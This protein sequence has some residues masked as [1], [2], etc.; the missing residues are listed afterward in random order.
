MAASG[1]RRGGAAGGGSLAEG[2]E[3]LKEACAMVVEDAINAVLLGLRERVRG[4]FG[5]NDSA[6]ICLPSYM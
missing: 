6:G 2:R 5:R 1:G 4:G 3:S